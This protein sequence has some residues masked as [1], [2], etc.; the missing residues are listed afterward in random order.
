LWTV[1]LLI[2]DIAR[3]HPRS[4]G[5]TMNGAV[6]YRYGPAIRFLPCRIDA[7]SRVA[8]RSLCFGWRWVD[9]EP[10]RV[11]GSRAPETTCGSGAQREHRGMPG[12]WRFRSPAPAPFVHRLQRTSESSASRA[13]VNCDG[14]CAG[15]AAYRVGGGDGLIAQGYKHHAAGEGMHAVVPTVAGGER[16]VG[17]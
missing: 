9:R 10:I 12:Q 1:E 3:M 4:S 14:D 8:P 15:D 7:A 5:S 11:K 16:V 17:G 6:S 13:R 2:L